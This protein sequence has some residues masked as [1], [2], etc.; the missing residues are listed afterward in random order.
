MKNLGLTR[1]GYV[2][3]C[4]VYETSMSN[5]R[6]LLAYSEYKRTGYIPKWWTNYVE[7]KNR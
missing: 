4:K 7:G 1:D 3:F 2:F 6:A 5:G